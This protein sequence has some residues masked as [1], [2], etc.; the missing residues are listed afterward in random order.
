MVSNVRK[1]SSSKIDRLYDLTDYRDE[2][3]VIWD[4]YLSILEDDILCTLEGNES[5]QPFYTTLL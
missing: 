5:N 4:F 2:S 3:D 1:M